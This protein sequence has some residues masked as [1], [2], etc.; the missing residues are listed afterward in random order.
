MGKQKTVTALDSS[1]LLYTSGT[2]YFV[3]FLDILCTLHERYGYIFPSRFI[4]SQIQYAGLILMAIVCGF[5]FSN[6]INTLHLHHKLKYNDHK[7]PLSNMDK[8]K[9]KQIKGPG[10]NL[11]LSDKGDNL[12]FAFFFNCKGCYC[13]FARKRKF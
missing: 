1:P 10:C 11:V 13:E 8:N 4:Q 9:G 7:I 12:D 3:F 2:G 6:I 5:L